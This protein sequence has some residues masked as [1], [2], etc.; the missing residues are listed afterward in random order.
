MREVRHARCQQGRTIERRCLCLRS[1]H[2]SKAKR[3][4]KRGRQT[5]NRDLKGESRR[6]AS[7]AN[8]TLIPTET[9]MRP[10]CS[11]QE[12]L[13]FN[14]LLLL[15]LKSAR[16]KND[17]LRAEHMEPPTPY[18]RAFPIAPEHRARRWRRRAR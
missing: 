13:F 11:G 8:E 5:V 17:A 15:V 18:L 6:G 7:I 2:Q 1:R 14:V 16:G 9:P 10:L 3:L 12:L 4:S